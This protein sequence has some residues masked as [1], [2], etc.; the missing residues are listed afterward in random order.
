MVDEERA[1]VGEAGEVGGEVAG[2]GVVAEEED[3]ELVEAGEGGGRE[4][5]AE[6][7]AAE[8][9][10]DDAGLL[11]LDASPLAV[12]EGLVQGEVEVVVEVGFGLEGE[13]GD[14]VVCRFKGRRWLGVARG[15]EAE[16]EEEV[17]EEVVHCGGTGWV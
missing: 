13:E 15:G 9:E 11:A 10:A 5:A 16:E 17:E 14:G 4:G 12:V 6:G 1:E 7:E 8:G 2:E 3:A